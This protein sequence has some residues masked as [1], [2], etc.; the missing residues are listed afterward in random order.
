MHEQLYEA[1]KTDLE[2]LIKACNAE[3]KHNDEIK[4]K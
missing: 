2:D 4:P 1:V 3:N